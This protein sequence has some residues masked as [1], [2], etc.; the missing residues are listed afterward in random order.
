MSYAN[1][2]RIVTDGL[3]MYL[4]AANRKSYPGSG[5]TWH[6]LS[7]NN[8]NGTFGASTAA[9]TFSGDNGGCLDFDGSNDYIDLGNPTSLS[10]LGGT[11]NISVSSWV[12]YDSYVGSGG[13]QPYS[14]ITV[15]GSPWTW[16]LENPNNRLRFRIT[17]GGSDVNI[18]DT[19]IHSLNTWYNVIGTY[20]GSNMKIY[21]NGLLKNTKAQTGTLGTNSITAKIGTF[22][23][24]NYNMNGK[25]SNVSI[26]NRAL[27][28]NEVRQN[29]EATKGR[30]GL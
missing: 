27:S 8:N 10:S 7:G 23:G 3:I 25:I 12:K 26:Y 16:L 30:F 22:Q 18:E 14:V 29:F 6:D 13:S 2:P 28:A 19:S 24:T 17:A 21:V 9:P 15:K 1:G 20:D 11:S 4:D 5:T